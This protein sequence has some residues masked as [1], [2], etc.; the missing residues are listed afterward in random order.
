[1]GSLARQEQEQ[2]PPLGLSARRRRWLADPI[3]WVLPVRQMGYGGAG[4]LCAQHAAVQRHRTIVQYQCRTT[5]P[6]A[7]TAASA[8]PA[9][10]YLCSRRACAPQCPSPPTRVPPR[11]RS[12]AHAG[13]QHPSVC[14]PNT[15]YALAGVS[16]IPK[17]QVPNA[18]C[19]APYAQPLSERASNQPKSL[20][21]RSSNPRPW[22]AALRS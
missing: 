21:G 2:R 13:P 18:R 16:G 8:C 22:R 4:S 7:P 20:V 19:S 17:S 9:Y 3:G 12:H 15:T 10:K 6:C 5:Q 11:R 14:C 1:V